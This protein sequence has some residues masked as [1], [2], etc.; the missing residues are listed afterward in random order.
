MK[1][2]TKKNKIKIF[3]QKLNASAL[4][5]VLLVIGIAAI[6]L[7]YMLS[8]VSVQQQ[9][10]TLEKVTNRSE[11]QAI[12]ALD[13][14]TKEY[15]NNPQDFTIT[16]SVALSDDSLN[17]C[18]PDADNLDEKCAEESRVLMKEFKQIVRYSLKNDETIEVTMA[19]SGST[20][21]AANSGIAVFA[22]PNTVLAGGKGDILL[23]MGFKYDTATGAL[24]VSGECVADF[25]SANK[26]SC[27]GD[28]TVVGSSNIAN[29][30]DSVK[31]DYGRQVFQIRSTQPITFYR[32]KAL[33][34]DATNVIP[35]S[36][37]GPLDSN[38]LPTDLPLKQV[39][40]F[41]AIVYSTG[42][43]K[44]Q[45]Y[46]ELT[47]MVWVH[48]QMPEVFDWVLFNGSNQPISK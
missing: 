47:R 21:S 43:T 5:I 26:V 6:V 38:D 19:E 23:I 40:V 32:I 1:H 24:G 7:V 30:V 27:L 2:L 46:T 34:A 17:I 48:P 35:V 45:T 4:V 36:V 39:Y 8:K 14:L 41:T 12:S 29:T 15:I 11:A 44:K 18:S 25:G 20:V 9:Q 42:S 28:L 31:N 3:S 16:P 10:Q 33:T 37:S 22:D 13:K